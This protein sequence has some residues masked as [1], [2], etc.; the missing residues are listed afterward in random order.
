MLWRAQRLVFFVPSQEGCNFHHCPDR[1][2]LR[3]QPS[4]LL[5]AQPLHRKGH[6]SGLS[7]SLHPIYVM[8]AGVKRLSGKLERPNPSL[9]VKIWHTCAST[10]LSDQWR[11]NHFNPDLFQTR[12]LSKSFIN[13]LLVSIFFTFRDIIK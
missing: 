8:R 4:V 9:C 6:I 11:T 5:R 12:C 2:R 7:P 10:V 3:S 13:F 1:T